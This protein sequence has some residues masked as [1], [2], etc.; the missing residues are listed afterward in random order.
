MAKAV[1]FVKVKTTYFT[2]YSPFK[3]IIRNFLVEELSALKYIFQT[4][5]TAV[6]YDLAGILSCRW[7]YSSYNNN[8]KIQQGGDKPKF[9][10]GG[11]LST[12]ICQHVKDF[13]TCKCWRSPF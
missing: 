10:Q 11:D 4:N 5:Y 13:S 2:L 1:C 12:K 9:Q 3:V 7:A 8:Q 6:F